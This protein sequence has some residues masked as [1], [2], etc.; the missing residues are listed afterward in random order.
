M[1]AAH[2]LGAAAA[3][4]AAQQ[5]PQPDRNLLLEARWSANAAVRAATSLPGTSG[6]SAAGVA[7]ALL[8]RVEV[9]R[10][11]PDRACAAMSLALSVWERRGVP[12]WLLAQAGALAGDVRMCAAA[13]HADPC[14]AAA[15]EVLRG[16]APAAAVPP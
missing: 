14:N 4:A 3:L 11:K 10:G 6:M 16:L 5:L 9:L 13:V 8:A 12:G 1:P 2:L 15:W 7:A